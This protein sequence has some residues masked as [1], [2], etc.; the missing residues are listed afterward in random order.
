M[1]R[2]HLV[3]IALVLESRYSSHSLKM[4]RHLKVPDELTRPTDKESFMRVLS[5]YEI[6]SQTVCP[7]VRRPK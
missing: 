6:R 5:Y 1:R 3:V 7:A 2:I 4:R